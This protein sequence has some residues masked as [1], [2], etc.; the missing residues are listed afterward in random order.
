MWPLVFALRTR[1]SNAVEFLSEMESPFSNLL[2][3]VPVHS[4][5]LVII[6]TEY[7]ESLSDRNRQ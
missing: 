5:F 3:S 2:L 1:L 6:T 4:C 7:D